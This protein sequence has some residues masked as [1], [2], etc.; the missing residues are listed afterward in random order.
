MSVKKP[1]YCPGTTCLCQKKGKDKSVFTQTYYVILHNDFNGATCSKT[2]NHQTSKLCLSLY[3]CC[4]CLVRYTKKVDARKCCPRWECVECGTWRPTQHD[5]VKCCYTSCERLACTFKGWPAALDMHVC[6]TSTSR[7]SGMGKSEVPPWAARGQVTK[8]DHKASLTPPVPWK[9]AWKI[10]P[11]CYD[12]VKAAGEYYILESIASQVVGRTAGAYR[13]DDTSIRVICGEAKEMQDA[14]VATFAPVFQAYANMAIGGE[15]RHHSAVG[16]QCLSLLRK[17]A[18]AGWLRIREIVGPQALLDAAEL[19]LEIKGNTYGGKKWAEA[20]YILH[21][22]ETGKISSKIFVDRMFSLQHNGGVFLNKVEWAVTNPN[23]YSLYY[24]KESVLPAHGCSPEPKYDVLLGACGTAVRQL[25]ADFWTI[26]GVQGVRPRPTINRVFSSKYSIP[27]SYAVKNYKQCLTQARLTL[28]VYNTYKKTSDYKDY[29]KMNLITHKK[30]LRQAAAW[31]LEIRA[32]GERIIQYTTV[33]QTMYS[34][35]KCKR[36]FKK[37]R[38]KIKLMLNTPF[39]TEPAPKPVPTLIPG[40]SDTQDPKEASL[41]ALPNPGGSPGKP[42]K[43][44]VI[45]H[46]LGCMPVEKE[47]VRASV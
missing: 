46:D 35:L 24:L 34:F 41:W 2:H 1:G 3:E 11:E 47:K 30:W 38:T 7:G 44:H 31:K 13:G 10:R 43:W 33:Q 9:D 40:L 16:G 8:E 37:S 29:A 26:A 25:F 18:W 27:E 20:C 12:P 42:H 15:L 45:C 28:G 39:N 21:A 5:A 22:Y 36:A 17:T 32:N 4:M 14:L 23:K 6:K 19:F